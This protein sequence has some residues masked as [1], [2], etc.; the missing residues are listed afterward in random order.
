MCG[1]VGIISEREDVD[2]DVV[3]RMRDALIHRGPD[4]AG[5]WIAPDRTV[6]LGH[7]R[8]SIVD[9]DA[10]HQPMWSSRGDVVIVYNGEVYNHLSAAGGARTA[11]SPLPHSM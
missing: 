8:L 9:L 2:R 6:G 7:R 3:T 11:G 1:I 4:E 5:L 10:G